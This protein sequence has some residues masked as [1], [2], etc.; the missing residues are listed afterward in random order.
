MI[1]LIPLKGLHKY[2]LKISELFWD[3]KIEIYIFGKTQKNQYLQSCKPN[4]TT[5]AGYLIKS[6]HEKIHRLSIVI[7]YLNVEKK[8]KFVEIIEWQKFGSLKWEC[9]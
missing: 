9:A 5:T 1:S 2:L 7:I 8:E 6:A 3:V 4:Y